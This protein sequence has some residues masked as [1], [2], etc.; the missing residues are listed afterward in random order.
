MGVVMMALSMMMLLAMRRIDDGKAKVR[1][2]ASSCLDG[3]CLHVLA[4]LGCKRLN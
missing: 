4:V 3:R 1:T 2:T